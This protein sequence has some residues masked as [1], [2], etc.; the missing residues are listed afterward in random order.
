MY[1]NDVNDSRGFHLFDTENYDIES[2]DNPYRMFYNV[3]YED[4]PHQLFDASEYADKIVKVIVRKKSNPKEFE[5]FIDKLYT[6]GVEELKVIENFDYNNGWIHPE[7]VD[8]AEDENTVSILHKYIEDS[9]VDLD[10]S[11]VKNIFA[12]LYSEACEV[13]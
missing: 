12:S 10:K 1:W 8:I 13:E 4:T 9:E 3:Y 5:K 11:R 6:V 2:I 7:D